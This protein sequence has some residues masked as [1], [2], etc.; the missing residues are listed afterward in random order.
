MINGGII[1]SIIC[2]E[3]E[4]NLC[5]M[6]LTSRGKKWEQISLKDCCQIG[7]LKLHTTNGSKDG[8]QTTDYH[9]MFIV[10]VRY[11]THLTF[12]ISKQYTERFFYILHFECAMNQGYG[13]V[14]TK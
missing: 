6:K 8:K 1:W 14:I 10:H 5:E 13:W 4:I 2:T 12:S 11:T 7:K 9:T 3:T